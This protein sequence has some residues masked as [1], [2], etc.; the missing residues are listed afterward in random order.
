MIGVGVVVFRGDKVLLIKRGKPPRIGQWSLPGGLQEVGETVFEAAKREIREEC[1]IEIETRAVIDIVDAI[2]PGE[3]GRIRF[4]YTL[5]EVLAEWKSGEPVAGDDA[6]D[7]AW[8]DPAAV[9]ELGMW[10]QTNRII[11]RGQLMREA[12]RGV[13]G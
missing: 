5:V 9:G 2:T 1:A 8:F 13:G 12:G 11:R 10:E 4:H 7:A 3:D 6:I